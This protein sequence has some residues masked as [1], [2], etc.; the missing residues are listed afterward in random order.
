MP[1]DKEPQS[2]LPQLIANPVAE[3]TASNLGLLF[4]ATSGPIT[5]PGNSYIG[6]MLRNP[7]ASEKRVYLS[8]IL[9]GAVANTSFSLIQNGKFAG[10]DP[11]TPYNANFGADADSGAK[12]KLIMQGSDPF[13]GDEPFSTVIPSGG[14]LVEELNGRLILPPKS[15]L[16]VRIAN[17]T[18]QPSLVSLSI[19]WWELGSAQ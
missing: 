4:E 5:M 13:E 9:Y 16:G 18:A 12:L 14:S 8:R 7:S 3:Y 19:S 2:R 17:N 10:G 1:K 15:S 6:I 11:L